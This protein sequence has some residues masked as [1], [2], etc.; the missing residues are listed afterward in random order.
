[1]CF[2][3]ISD[4]SLHFPIDIGNSSSSHLPSTKNVKMIY[5]YENLD[6]DFLKM[7][8][9]GKIPIIICPV[10]ECKLVI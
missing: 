8:N 7:I 9:M 10:C 5:N 2:E 6:P 4:Y 1:M 3:V